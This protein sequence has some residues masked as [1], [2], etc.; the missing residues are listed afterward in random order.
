MSHNGIAGT[1]AL[2]TGAARGIGRA[3]AARLAAEGAVVAAADLD[4]DALASLV[5]DLHADGHKAGFYTADVRDSASVEQM[6]DAVEHDLGPIGHAVNVAGVLATGEVADTPDAE[7]ERVLAVNATGV[8][9]VSRAAARRMAPRGSGTITTVGSN[10]AGVPRS[11]MAAYGASKAAATMFTK[12]LGL[13]LA[14]RGIRCNVV[15]PGSTDTPMQRGMWDGG[16]GARRVIAG[17]PEEFRVGIPLGRIADP[18]DVAE[19]VCFLASSAARHITMHDLYV[20]GGA[21]LRA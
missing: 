6:A 15:S 3:V 2:V 8:F 12:S 5:G 4:A 14:P 17:A 9:N 13:E 16:D 20:D 18:A 7:W 21:T 1:V 11:G 10:A 19:A